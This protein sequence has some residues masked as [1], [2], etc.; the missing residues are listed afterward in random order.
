MW[1]APLPRRA[2]GSAARSR[3]STSPSSRARSATTTR[4]SLARRG[5]G[6]TRRARSSM[7]RYARVRPAKRRGERTGMIGEN[8]QARYREDGYLHVQG[9]FDTDEVAEMR[10]AVDG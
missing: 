8:E 10:A 7:P 6:A 9:V 3:T 2:R 5:D 4:F 1:R